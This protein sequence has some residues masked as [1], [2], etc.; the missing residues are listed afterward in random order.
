METIT[1]NQATLGQACEIICVDAPKEMPDWEPWL[2]ELGF[3]AGES[4]W[5]T[6][7]SFLDGGALVVRVG[8]STFALNPD[9]AGCVR[10]K[11]HAAA[12]AGSS[13][14]TSEVGA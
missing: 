11:A 12:H 3:I 13:I 4:V 10:V 7:R 6:R 2:A 9:E 5:V 1:L 8:Q 14:L